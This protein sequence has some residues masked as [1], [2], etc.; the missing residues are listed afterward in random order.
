VGQNKVIQKDVHVE[1]TDLPDLVSTINPL[2]AGAVT[3]SRQAWVLREYLK[4]HKEPLSKLA[5]WRNL[6]LDQSLGGLGVKKPYN[7][8]SKVTPVQRLYAQE[9]YAEGGEFS[10]LSTNGPWWPEI[11]NFV[12]ED[13]PWVLAPEKKEFSVPRLGPLRKHRKTGWFRGNLF[14][15]RLRLVM[16]PTEFRCRAPPLAKGYTVDSYVDVVLTDRIW[17][18][19]LQYSSLELATKEVAVKPVRLVTLF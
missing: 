16:K 6:F 5:G 3:R 11:P 13:P 8:R 7:W 1:E 2:L 15:L 19:D 9:R 17:K 4:L 18:Q 14:G 12:R 10:Q